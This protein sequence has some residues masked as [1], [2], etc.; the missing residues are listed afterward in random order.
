V[1]QDGGNPRRRVFDAIDA[2]MAKEDAGECL[3]PLTMEGYSTE[4]LIA[5]SE[6]ERNHPAAIRWPAGG[7]PPEVLMRDVLFKHVT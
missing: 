4:H 3:H 6:K 5:L 2:A 1:N 7:E